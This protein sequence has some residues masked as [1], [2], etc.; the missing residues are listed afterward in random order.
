VYG[1][2]GS[3]LHN[4]HEI[5]TERPLRHAINP[6]ALSPFKPQIPPFVLIKAEGL[7]SKR[8]QNDQPVEMAES[9]LPVLGRTSSSRARRV[10]P[11]A[12]FRTAR[13]L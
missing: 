11:L 9:F 10:G 8:H 5:E 13:Y 1:V 12:H 4:A 2:K 6:L 3:L 7:V